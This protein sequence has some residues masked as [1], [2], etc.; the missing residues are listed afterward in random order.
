MLK[1]QRVY[2]GFT[3]MKRRDFVKSVAYGAGF[4]GLCSMLGYVHNSIPDDH[5]S[6]QLKEYEGWL[7]NVEVPICYHCNLNCAYC[8]HFAPLAHE[9][10]MPVEVFERDL[11]QLSKLCDSKIKRFAILGGEPLLHNEIEKICEIA[12]KYLPL[13][14]TSRMIITNGLLLNDMPESFWKVCGESKIQVKYS[15]YSKFKNYPKDFNVAHKFANKYNVSLESF[16]KTSKFGKMNLVQ[17]PIYNKEKNYKTCHRDFVSS[18][19]DNGK[20]YSCAQTIGS[21]KFFN[22]YFKNHALPTFETDELDIY[23]VSSIDEIFEYLNRPKE[24]CKYCGYFAKRERADW[25]LSN[26]DLCEWYD[27]STL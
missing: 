1:C 20:L 19:L 9:Y 2:F 10:C 12:Y 21:I 27:C 23:K 22:E 26:R 24:L 18:L 8:D 7:W 13:E 25:Q 17:K 6:K 3:G 5:I 15:H 16:G 4:A 11:K 14:K